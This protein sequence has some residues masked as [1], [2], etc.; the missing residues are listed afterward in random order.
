MRIDYLQYTPALEGVPDIAADA[1]VAGRVHAGPGLVLRAHA[2]LR[3][4][5]EAI[6]VGAGC[7][8]GVRA[9]VHIADGVYPAIIGDGVSV[10]R[11]GLVHACTVGDG[12][13]VADAAT[14]M[15]GAA[16]GA[17][18]LIMPGAVVPPR[19]SLTGGVVYAGSPA[20]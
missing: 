3:A 18:A 2:T 4:D 13:V 14:V 7:F 10:G 9:T 5:G 16:V 20:V 15:D 12:V 17:H 1:L 19:K 8:F 6:R 11:Y